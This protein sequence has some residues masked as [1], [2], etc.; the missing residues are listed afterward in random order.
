MEFYPPVG[1]LIPGR[2]L[3]PGNPTYY[4]NNPPV[5]LFSP[6]RLCQIFGRKSRFLVSGPSIGEMSAQR[7]GPPR[8]RG[9]SGAGPV[10]SKA[11]WERGNWPT[12]YAVKS[13]RWLGKSRSDNCVLST[14][15]LVGQLNVH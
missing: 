1:L 7:R 15:T 4:P 12:T 14:S 8:F 10:I 13:G 3:A 6:G 2:G 5:G 9:N 11:D